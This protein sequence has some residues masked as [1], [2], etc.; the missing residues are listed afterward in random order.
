MPDTEPQHPTGSDAAGSVTFRLYA[1]AREAAGTSTL[2]V[3]PGRTV[4]VL[5]ALAAGRSPRFASV[6]AVSSLMSD[7]YRLDRTAA[8]PL[9]AGT[10]VDVL[11]PFAGG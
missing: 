5:A 2:H 7:G 9:D 4:D 3:A 6:L 8:T 11:P 10:V 1:S